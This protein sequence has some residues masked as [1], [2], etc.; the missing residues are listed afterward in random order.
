MVISVAYCNVEIDIRLLVMPIHVF[1]LPPPVFFLFF[2]FVPI[3]SGC[4]AFPCIIIRMVVD[5][6]YIVEITSGWL[7]TAST[8]KASAVTLME[9]T[10]FVRH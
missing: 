4:S 7:M 5:Y 2:I 1:R 10:N 3:F 6:L 9:A 8:T